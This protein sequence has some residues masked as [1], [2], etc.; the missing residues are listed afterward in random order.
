MLWGGLFVAPTLYAWVRLSTIMFPTPGMKSALCK[1]LIE[2][3]S[4]TPFAMTSFYF[5][6]SLLESKTVREAISEVATKVPPTYKVALMVWPSVA[7]INFAFIPE[8]NRVPFISVCSLCWTTFLA[9][10]KQLEK[11]QFIDVDGKR[12]SLFGAV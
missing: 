10:V 2:Q 12:K 7:F 8:R 11:Q 5:G 3:I 9:Y 1:A 6:M 4:Y